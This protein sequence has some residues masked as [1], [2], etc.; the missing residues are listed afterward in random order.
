LL[1]VA[2]WQWVFRGEGASSAEKREHEKEESMRKRR[3]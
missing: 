1:R 2:G 3:A